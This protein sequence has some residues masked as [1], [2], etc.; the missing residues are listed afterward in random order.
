MNSRN[1]VTIARVIARLNV[2]G[3]AIQAISM[4]KAFRE[5]GYRTILLTGQI[6]DGEGSMEHLADE[7]G[8]VPVRIGTM[9][10]RISWHRDLAAVW[11]L[12]RIFRR[13]KPLI[14]HTHTAKAGTLGRLAAI[15]TRVPVRVHTFH[16]HVFQGYFSPAVTRVF[17][18]IERFLARHTDRIIAL[19]QSQKHDLAYTYRVAPAEKIAVVPLGFGLE[20]FLAVNG[21]LGTLRQSMGC[22][23]DGF[24]VGWV[25]RLTEIKDP[26]LFLHCARDLVHNFPELRFAVIGDGELRSACEEM[27]DA[28]EFGEK[29]C[30][31]GWQQQLDRIYA[32]LDL[33]VL[34][35]INEGTPLALLEAMASGK[36]FVST[37]VGGVRDLMVG[38]AHKLDG[39]EIFENGILVPRQR[40]VLA[41]AI[42]Y[43]LKNPEMLRSM[44]KSGRAFV[45]ARFSNQRLADDLESLYVALVRAKTSVQP[46]S[47]SLVPGSKG[48][49]CPSC[50]PAPRKG[51]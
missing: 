50:S 33:V 5:R 27:V 19:S 3:P 16:G 22:E 17:L 11:Q 37:D 20:S 48:L 25:G 26:D 29:V 36:A 39:F 30:F 14:V 4:T 51:L 43:L 45:R 31:M 34:T 12:I 32:D 18:A 2:G 6:P 24:L 9:S 15:V 7:M 21:R 47:H 49:E 38:S 35:S 28:A 10:R 23:K 1:K 13:E 44:G 40:D 41:R 46:E 8:V 42:T